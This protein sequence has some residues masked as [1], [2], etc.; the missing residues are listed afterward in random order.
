LWCLKQAVKIDTSIL[1]T[2]RFIRS[3]QIALFKEKIK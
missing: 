1:F 2:K 3:L